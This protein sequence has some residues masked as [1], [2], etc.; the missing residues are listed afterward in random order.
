M[1]V[2]A[3]GEAPEGLLIFSCNLRTFSL[4]AGVSGSYRV[5]DWTK[6]SIPKDFERSE[7][8]HHCFW[9]RRR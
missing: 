5:E 7:R 2:V 4:D 3:P 8:I 9:I 6:P 1:R